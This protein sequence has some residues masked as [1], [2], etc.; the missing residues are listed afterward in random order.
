MFVAV[1]D[2][3][4]ISPRNIPGIFF[5]LGCVLVD[6]ASAS[7]HDSSEPDNDK[8][9]WARKE[10]TAQLWTIDYY[11]TNRQ[12]GRRLTISQH[13]SFAGDINDATCVVEKFMMTVLECLPYT[14][15]IDQEHRI[16]DTVWMRTFRGSDREGIECSAE[17]ELV[18]D[19]SG[20]E[21]PSE[22]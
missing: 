6:R 22:F 19:G 8:Q 4:R 3:M 20:D 12:H 7:C 15:M 1:W 10:Q 11:V 13:D 18:D 16:H 9:A 21:T 2:I 14:I 17:M 5:C